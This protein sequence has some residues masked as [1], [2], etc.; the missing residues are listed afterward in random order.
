ML[1]FIPSEIYAS[2]RKWFYRI[3]ITLISAIIWAML[4]NAPYAEYDTNYALL[5]Y[6]LIIS[7]ITYIGLAIYWVKKRAYW[8]EWIAEAVLF[9]IICSP[10]TIAYICFHIQE[11]FGVYLKS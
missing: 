1:I 5:M 7:I 2:K 10:F 11:I 4:I 6:S 3:V 8:K 9:T